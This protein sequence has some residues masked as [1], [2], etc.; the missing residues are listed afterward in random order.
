MAMCSLRSFPSVLHEV[1]YAYTC[2]VYFAYLMFI[3]ANSL[4]VVYGLRVLV[5][6]T[7]AIAVHLLC[8]SNDKSLLSNRTCNIEFIVS[9]SLKSN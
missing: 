9:Q 5:Y 8:F 3:V 6:Y 1:F 7:L 2:L 4:Y